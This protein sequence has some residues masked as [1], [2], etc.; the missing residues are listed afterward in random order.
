MKETL[1]GIAASAGTAKGKV[2]IIESDDDVLAFPNNAVLVATM[3]D[4]SMVF[5][6]AK[7]S[8]IVT[9]TGGITSHP[10]IVSRELGIPCVVNTKKATTLLKDGDKVE[11]N[12]DKGTV[13]LL[14]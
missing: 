13:S 10:A 3:T 4:P 8:A 6:M 7:S 12:G 14:S 9:N 1:K 2:K 11:V 5:A